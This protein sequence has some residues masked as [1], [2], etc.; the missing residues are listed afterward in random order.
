MS[1]VRT[2]QPPLNKA[3]YFNGVDAYVV[4]P[5]TVYG[6]SGITVQEWLCPLYP[7]SNAAWSKFSMIGDYWTDL[8][9]V[10][11]HVFL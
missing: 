5:L 3:M 6:W 4:I 7:K 8:P 2:I 1:I 11:T 9:A 10:F